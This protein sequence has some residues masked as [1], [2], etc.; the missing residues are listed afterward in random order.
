MRKPNK[1]W[2][3]SIHQFH[4]KD[5]TKAGVTGISGGG[6]GSSL[7]G[8]QTCAFECDNQLVCDY[9]ITNPNGSR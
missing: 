4:M 3:E 9:F 2:M 7:F 1:S 6:L 5:L 8:M